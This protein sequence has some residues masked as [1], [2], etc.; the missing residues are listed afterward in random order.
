MNTFFLWAWM[1]LP[2]S[3][4][5]RLEGYKSAVTLMGEPW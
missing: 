4:F 5:V 2:F 3:T 1:D